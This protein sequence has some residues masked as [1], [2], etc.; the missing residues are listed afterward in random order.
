M[1]YFNF[2]STMNNII[3]FLFTKIVLTMKRLKNKNINTTPSIVS[4][5][6]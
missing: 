4:Y 2:F 1:K 3:E 5:N 6:G